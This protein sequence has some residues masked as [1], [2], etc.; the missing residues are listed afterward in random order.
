MPIRD[1]A[2]GPDIGPAVL[3]DN[4]KYLIYKITNNVNGRYYIGRHRTNNINDH[5]MGSGK[6]II[7]AIKKYGTDNFSKE[8]IAETWNESDLWELE[9][10]L[11]NEEIVKDPKSY[12]MS[13]GGKHYLHGL[14]TYD[15][16]GFISHQ[17]M[18]GLKGGPACYK[19]KSQEEKSNWHKK[20]YEAGR[21]KHYQRNARCVYRLTTNAN[22][23]FVLNGVEFREMCR[24]NGW[25][26][27]T[28]L[29]KKSLGKQ[30]SR[31]P[32]KGFR[33][34]KLV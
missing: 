24:N 10:L 30:I 5:Y 12:N 31:G 8:I 21:E 23:E 22:T 28:L 33:V 4:M 34:D 18:A 29:W 9:K 20:G 16:E 32:L 1:L 14:K 27:N 25:N 17:R 6:A 11:V 26:H 7:N 13:Y 19:Q 3:G 2:Q 15:P